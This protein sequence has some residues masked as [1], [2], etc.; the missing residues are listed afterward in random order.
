[1]TFRQ[2]RHDEPLLI[3]LPGA[4]DGESIALERVPAGLRRENLSLP[5]LEEF[6]VARHFTRLSQ[7]NYG[8]D[9]GFYPLGSCTMKYNPKYAESLAAS[10]KARRLH[11]GQPEE[12]VQG[13]LQI[14]YELQEMIAR[15]AGMDKVSLQPVAG[16]QGELAGLL[17]A[18]AYF[19][20]RGEARTQVV[21]PDT[22][23]GTNFASAAM[24]GYEVVEIPSR[25]GVVDLEALEG[26]LNEQTA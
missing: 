13:A 4:E 1:M 25:E 7:M 20:E 24:A 10:P 17:M 14:L 8:T 18:R 12:T 22:A 5:N 16:A 2:A 19:E 23:H 11:P 26:A 9:S 3:D 21:L 15:I 6:Q